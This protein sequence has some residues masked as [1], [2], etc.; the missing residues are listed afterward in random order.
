MQPFFQDAAELL[1]ELFIAFAV[2]FEQF[3]Q[4]AEHLGR[5]GL[6]DLGE[7]RILLQDFT[8]HVQRQVVG[9]HH[10]AHEAQ[11]IREQLLA[12]VGDEHPLHIELQPL[13]LDVRHQQIER[14]LLRQEQQRL[15][16]ADALRR[17][18]DR[19]QIIGAAE[20]RQ[21]RIEA[22]VLLLGDFGGFPQPDRLLRVEHLVGD[23]FG[24]V[25]VDLDLGQDDRVFDE[26]GILLHDAADLPAFQI[27]FGVAFQIELD[28]GARLLLRGGV[29]LVFALSVAG[30]AD[31]RGVGT[32]LLCGQL[33]LFGHH[34]RRVETD[35]ELA[36]QLRQVLLVA[37]FLKHL[38]E[39]L[40]AALG[41]GADVFDDLLLGHADAVVGDGQGFVRLVDREADLPLFRE[42]GPG[43]AFKTHLVDRVGGVGH[44]F[45]QENIAVGV[46]RMN[47]QIQQL[48]DFRLE[49]FF[50]SHNN[51]TSLCSK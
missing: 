49:L 44:Q 23:G 47:H 5:H 9:I 21:M 14:R 6:F 31:R 24:L 38:Q 25:V 16:F 41:D 32:G 27:L 19:L 15:E 11:V 33:H 46:Q 50:L 7:V 10:A 4:F 28:F 48:A 8:R 17:N 37:L 43:Q 13:L 3:L 39:G 34:E 30:P 12:L 2:G 29:K 40:G 42:F 22:L 51:K 26:V 20:V 35:A 1:E 45:A 18:V 36:D